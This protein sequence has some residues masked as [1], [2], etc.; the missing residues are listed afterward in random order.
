VQAERHPVY[1]IARL[2]EDI[3][4]GLLVTMP[5]EKDFL[6]DKVGFWC[7]KYFA[8]QREVP[9]IDR[10]RLLRLIENLTLG[11]AA[12]GYRTESMQAPGRRR[13]SAS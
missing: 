4:G 12:V 7:D 5:S 13:R 6:S 11:T 2:A 3:A 9:T 10:M 8:G 1:E